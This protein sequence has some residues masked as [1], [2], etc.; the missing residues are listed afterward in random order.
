MFA[1][2]GVW[3]GELADN[4]MVTAKDL[5]EEFKIPYDKKRR[6]IEFEL[7]TKNPSIA[8]KKP[9]GKLQVS[10]GRSILCLI[11]GTVNGETCQLRYYTRKI[12]RPGD[13]ADTYFPTKLEFRGRKKLIDSE[14]DLEELVLFALSNQCET[15]PF[16]KSTNSFAYSIVD[17]QGRAEASI[18]DAA[19]TSALR[20]KVL[21]HMSDEHIIAFAKGYRSR[22][23]FTLPI[24][25]DASAI[26]CRVAV[27][28][29]IE[30]D[31]AWVQS[32]LESPGMLLSGLVRDAMDQGKI[33]SSNVG[34][35]KISWDYTDG[36][37][38]GMV[39]AKLPGT[40]GLVEHLITSGKTE[41][42]KQKIGFFNKIEDYEKGGKVIAK[43]VAPVKEN[44]I[45]FAL[46]NGLI[47]FDGE[48]VSTLKK[49][50]NGVLISDTG[51]T[52]RKV[53]EGE[54]W[55]EFIEN[56]SSAMTKIKDLVNSY[57]NVTDASTQS[58]NSAT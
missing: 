3:K 8:T 6:I 24:Q 12:R 26:E 34:G 7:N 13:T 17:A 41:E 38:I 57:K 48:K 43:N 30:K 39:D 33:K 1:I 58:N 32:A 11:E 14:K 18:K 42:F 49:E 47:T 27:V 19:V 45:I 15:S 9:G 52:I 44:P 4:K 22:N 29:Q 55:M 21:N 28:E 23:R 40:D 37:H 10:K 16:R 5:I 56:N 25:H 35:G 36:T 50:I 51:R 2:T 46:T 31:R 53:P 54:N 20:D